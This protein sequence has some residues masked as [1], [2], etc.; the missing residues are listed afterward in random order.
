MPSVKIFIGR[1]KNNNIGFMTTF[2]TP[3]TKAVISAAQKPSTE[4]PGKTYEVPN[5]ARVKIIQ[6]IKTFIILF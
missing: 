2:T 4:T 1:V 5:I 6:F 3:K